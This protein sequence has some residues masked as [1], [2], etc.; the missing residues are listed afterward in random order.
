MVLNLFLNA[1]QEL[2]EL[3]LTTWR[4]NGKYRADGDKAVARML[5][6]PAD[7]TPITT[8]RTYF[9]DRPV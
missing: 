2:L 9:E 3:A 4:K 7:S 1:P 5:G 6:L 8:T